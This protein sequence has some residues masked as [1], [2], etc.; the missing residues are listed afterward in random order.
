MLYDP[1]RE[2]LSPP[3]ANALPS[4]NPHTVP[5]LPVAAA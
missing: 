4:N 5:G 2:P 1:L 3:P